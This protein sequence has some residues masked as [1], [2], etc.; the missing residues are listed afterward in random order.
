MYGLFLQNSWNYLCRCLHFIVLKKKF[1]LIF[2][3]AP[4]RINLFDCI[5]PV[6]VDLWVLSCSRQLFF[7]ALGSALPSYSLHHANPRPVH[8][9]FRGVVWG[10]GNLDDWGLHLSL[11][12]SNVWVIQGALCYALHLHGRT[13]FRSYLVLCSTRHC[14][15][16]QLFLLWLRSYDSCG[17][18]NKRNGGSFWQLSVELAFL[19]CRLSSSWILRR[20]YDYSRLLMIGLPRVTI[21]TYRFGP[22]SRWKM[23]SWWTA[24]AL[25]IYSSKNKKITFSICFSLLCLVSRTGQALLWLKFRVADC[26]W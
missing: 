17:V 18:N 1:S 15:G 6:S 26:G 5:Y 9:S 19:D 11:A 3:S 20:G 8:V 4:W 10:L 23:S 14:N 13:G 2:I 16:G 24:Q 21:S 25:W 22:Y 7:L 12:R